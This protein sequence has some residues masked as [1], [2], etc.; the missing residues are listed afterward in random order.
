MKLQDAI[1]VLTTELENDSSYREAWQA[2]I[3]MAYQDSAR[4]YRE[5][6]GK[7][8]L[9][10]IDEWQVSNNAANYFLNLL[11]GYKSPKK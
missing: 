4:W 10:R 5:K 11:C 7:R 6:T 8:R 2:N 9:N 1:Q 3:A